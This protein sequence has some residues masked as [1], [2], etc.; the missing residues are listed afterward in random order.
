MKDGMNPEL[1]LSIL[2]VVLGVIW[3]AHGVPKLTG[4]IE[5]TAGFFGQLGIPAPV[6]AA[7]FVALL[8]SLGGFLLLIGWLVA[9]VALLLSI[10]MLVAIVLAHAPNGFYVVGAGQGGIE[11]S[12]LLIASLLALIFCGPGLAAVDNRGTA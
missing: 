12:L 11:F 8:E 9:P 10:E 3:L 4:G 1:G 7:W 2:R 6:L 5:G